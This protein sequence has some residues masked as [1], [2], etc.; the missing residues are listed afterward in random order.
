MH[1]F[2]TKFSCC[3]ELTLPPLG[4]GRV[5]GEWH[6]VPLNAERRVLLVVLEI[7]VPL[8]WGK[9]KQK[10]SIRKRDRNKKHMHGLV[11]FML[12]QTE[13]A[14]IEQKFNH[15]TKMMGFCGKQYIEIKKKKKKSMRGVNENVPCRLHIHLLDKTW[16]NRARKATILL[17]GIFVFTVV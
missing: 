5:T 13:V 3:L 14:F 6:S 2:S 7:Y 10:V 1:S 17:G 4:G 8:S 16:Q 11:T 15:I 12:E 9:S